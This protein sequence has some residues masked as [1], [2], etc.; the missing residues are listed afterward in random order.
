MP[1]PFCPLCN[2]PDIHRYH[3][4]A[5]RDYTQCRQCLLVYVDCSQHLSLSQEKAIYDLHQNTIDDPGYIEFL[6][7][8]AKP[9]LRK[10]PNNSVGLDYGCGP[11]PALA[12]LFKAQGHRVN[13]YDP[14]YANFPEHLQRTYDFIV[15]TEVVEHFRVP[16]REFDTL[17]RLLK[18]GGWLGIMTKLVIDAEAFAKWHYKNDQ[19]H[20]AF[21]SQPTFHWLAAHYHCR[22]EFIGNDAIILQRNP[23]PYNN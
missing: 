18:P 21:F 7:R 3:S 4:D 19:T 20:I 23:G 5:K 14:F 13:V 15:C 9:L 8:L 6:S 12:E 10:L 17:F 1:A 22:I 16:K 11:G 2:S